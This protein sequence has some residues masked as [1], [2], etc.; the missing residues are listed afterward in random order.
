MN[1]HYLML[2]YICFV[3]IGSILPKDVFAQSRNFEEIVVSFEIPQLV[4]NDIFVQY[5]GNT[6]YLPLVEIFNILDLTIEPDFKNQK[7]SGFVITK[8]RRFTIDLKNLKAKTSGKEWPLIRTD[9]YLTPTEVYLQID[10][11][12]RLFDLKID[13]NFS[14]LRVYMPLNKDLPSYQKLKRKQEHER[15]QAKTIAMKD[16]TTLPYRRNYLG[17]G[18][19]DWALSANPINGGEQYYEFNAGAMVLGGDI[20]INGSGNS[21]NGFES[22]Q[23]IYKW[24]YFVDNNKY[25]TQADL[26][27]INTSGSLSRALKGGMISNKPQTERKYFQTI[28]LTDH[29]GQGWEVELYIDQRLVDFQYT[30]G[31]GDYNFNID[32]YYGASV[33]TL[34]MYGPNGEIQ[35]QERYIR[36]P[37]NLIPKKNIE[38]TL[39][40]GQSTIP[41]EKKNYAQGSLAYGISDN[42]TI[43][44]GSDYPINIK[45]EEKSSYAAEATYQLGGSLTFN[46]SFSPGNANRYAISFS[47]PTLAN[48]NATYT[49]YQPN[50]FRNKLKQVHNAFLSVSMPVKLGGRYIGLRYN[51]LWDR[52]PNADYINMNYGFNAS[53]LKFQLSYYGKYKMSIY[54]NHSTQNLSS[55]FLLSAPIVPFIQPQFRGTYNHTDNKL[56]NYSIILNKRLFKTGQL[57]VSYERNESAKTDMYLLTFN[58]FTNFASF[59]S[60][61]LSADN[62]TSMS[63]VQRGSVRFDSESNVLR[64]DRR[65]S[66]GYGS[67][68]IRPFQD[69]NFNGIRDPDE[70]YVSGI[71]AKISGGREKPTGRDK[72]FYYDGLRPYEEYVVQIDQASIDNPMLK[73]THENYKISCNPNVVTA[74]EVPLVPTSELSGFVER[75]TQGGKAGVGGIKVLL[76]NVTTEVLTEVTAFSSGEFYCEGMIPGTYRAYI[77]PDQ[78][79]KYG[80]N[81][82]PAALEFE[83]KPTDSGTCKENINFLLIPKPE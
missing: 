78:L 68:V 48:V 81:C 64:F 79:T 20:T 49:Q 30:D 8:D 3:I 83:I 67:A 2:L 17:G 58:F 65:N 37:Y 73:P 6:I 28:N 54:S 69:E 4:K 23:L 52:F 77:D 56:A 40:M 53:V 19:I 14:A 33:L 41:I 66:V 16:V 38:Y 39:A 13:F 76:M 5:D 34:K 63:Q 82:E 9:Y 61:V 36:I 59:T 44:V 50:A 42:L 32:I 43:G 7:F 25:L 51:A 45:D 29:L 11:F 75:Q 47:K 71:R 57:S 12:Y 35:S 31:H 55:Q 74:I 15:L 24:H 10:L 80:Y 21:A 26:G 62:T 22:D 27:Y 72:I 60:K 46:T 70:M 18:I 1:R